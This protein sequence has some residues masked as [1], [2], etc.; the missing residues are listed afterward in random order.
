MK[1]IFRLIPWIAVVLLAI[2]LLLARTDAKQEPELVINRT[3]V[4]QEIE[5]LGKM[6]LV[7]YNF[8][9]I[10]ELTQISETYFNLFKLGPDQ[11]IA[12]ISTGQA[13]G[14]VDLTKL[15]ESDVRVEND[16]LYVKL[17]SP[18]ICYYKLDMDKTRIY[19][20]ETN[21]LKDERAFIQEAYKQAEDEI[22]SAALSSGILSQTRTNAELILKPM[23]EKISGRAVV[24]QFSM[25][26]Q[27]GPATQRK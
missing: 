18:E 13:V 10:T 3:A 17:P 14:C 9:E 25:D 11:K 7:K 15:E 26:V 22:R 2:L 8:K 4:L 19:N 6:E 21:W 20:L 12:L 27:I 24:I 16:T 5:A 1:S 23:L